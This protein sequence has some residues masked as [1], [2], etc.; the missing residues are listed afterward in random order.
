MLGPLCNQTVNLKTDA[1]TQYC[2][3]Y[4]E[5]KIILSSFYFKAQQMLKEICIVKQLTAIITATEIKWVGYYYKST[6]SDQL[7]N[8]CILQDAGHELFCVFGDFYASEIPD[9]EVTKSV[10][11]VQWMELNKINKSY[12]WCLCH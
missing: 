12:S 7:F 2:S 3:I 11:M 6:C 1:K 10:I 8:V 9:T 5:I 4:T